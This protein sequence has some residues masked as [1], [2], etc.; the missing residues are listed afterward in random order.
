MEGKELPKSSTQKWYKSFINSLKKLAENMSTCKT[1]T[2]NDMFTSIGSSP[3][4]KNLIIELLDELDEEIELRNEIEKERDPISWFKNKVVET[5]NDMAKDGIISTPT[6]NEFETL[7]QNIQDS[8]GERIAEDA[9]L[10]AR[11]LD[12]DTDEL[13]SYEKDGLKKKVGE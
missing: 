7:Y 6:Q 1:I 4:T 10:A 12:C 13:T 9:E 3:E 2:G 11:E 5:M 8:I